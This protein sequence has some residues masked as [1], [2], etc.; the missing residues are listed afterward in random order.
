MEIL[1]TG[2]LG[3]IGSHICVKLLNDNYKVV[4]IDNPAEAVFAIS[5]TC[6]ITLHFFAL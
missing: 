5:V 1:L 2:G 3:F 4:I 6:A